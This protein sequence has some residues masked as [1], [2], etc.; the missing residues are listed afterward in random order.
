MAV[1]AVLMFMIIF[2]DQ[3]DAPQ[4]VDIVKQLTGMQVCGDRVGLIKQD[5][6]VGDLLYEF[7]VVSGSDQCFPGMV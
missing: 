6:A 5:R 7:E 3:I 2:I 1:S 4:Q